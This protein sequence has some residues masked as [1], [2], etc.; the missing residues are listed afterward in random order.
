MRWV[1]AI[2]LAVAMAFSMSAGF[3]TAEA[4]KKPKNKLCMA[5]SLAGAKASWKCSAAEKCCY[6]YLLSKGNC[7]SASQ[8][9]L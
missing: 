7:I 8:P 5:T 6:D 9:C 2:G 3:D 4:A 1:A